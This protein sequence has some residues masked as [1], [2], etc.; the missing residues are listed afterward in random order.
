MNKTKIQNLIITES[1]SKDFIVND[2]YKSF[3]DDLIAKH[4]RGELKLISK[5]EIV[6]IRKRTFK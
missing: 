5:E 3:M 1:N 4:K 6:K 2:E